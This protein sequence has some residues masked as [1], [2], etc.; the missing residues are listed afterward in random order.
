RRRRQLPILAHAG[1]T[2]NPSTAKI[3]LLEFAP[4]VARKRLGQ[5]FERLGEPA[6]RANQVLGRLW[7]TP[8]GTFDAMSELPKRL[9]ES[10]A[11]EFELPRLEIAAH[12]KSTDGTEKFLL[13]LRDNEAIETVAIPEGDR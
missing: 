8:V 4:E 6:Y 3:N 2:V 5:F 13:R 1:D 10:L 7:Q 12:Q 11:D 9:R